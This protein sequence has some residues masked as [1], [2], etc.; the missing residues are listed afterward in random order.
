MLTL[1]LIVIVIVLIADMDVFKTPTKKTGRT[2][3]TELLLNEY[4][5]PSYPWSSHF[6]PITTLDQL[7]MLDRVI[8]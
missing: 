3:M 4:S 1:I 7:K 5:R 2:L 8:P 6:R